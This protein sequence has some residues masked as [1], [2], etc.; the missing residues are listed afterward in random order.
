MK[1]VYIVQLGEEQDLCCLVLG[2][3]S[4]PRYFP[5]SRSTYVSIVHHLLVQEWWGEVALAMLGVF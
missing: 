4:I 5:G 1:F 3:I 2:F